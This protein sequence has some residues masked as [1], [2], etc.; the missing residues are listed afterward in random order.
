MPPAA[1]NVTVN[2]F[3]IGPCR[4]TYDG[5]DLGGTLSNVV[6]NF[7]YEKAKL[8]A[9]Q[10]GNTLLDEAISGMEVTVETEIAEVKDKD[11]LKKVFPNATLVTQVSPAAKA[12]DW[13]NQVST[14]ML[15]NAKVLQLHPLEYA[16][17]VLDYDWYFYQAMPS[18]E[19]SYT[20]SPTEQGKMK[21]VWKVYL[22]LTQTPP[23]MFRIGDNT[24]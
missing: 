6:V 8:M 15:A 17:A 18:E 5:V 12:L 1:A 21:I 23:K 14:R 11:T 4:V 7:K 22:D 19:S 2:N 24:I 13:E 16:D 9:D 3:E 20:L 10:Y